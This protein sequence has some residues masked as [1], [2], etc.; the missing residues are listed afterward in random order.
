[1][2]D[3]ITIDLIRAAPPLSSLD[4]EELP[5]RFTNAFVDRYL[6]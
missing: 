3:P 4:L 6:R 5:R 1:M 2:F